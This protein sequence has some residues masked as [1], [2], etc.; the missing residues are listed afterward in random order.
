MMWSECERKLSEEIPEN[1]YVKFSEEETAEND[2]E[3]AD[4]RYNKEIVKVRER[5]ES[6]RTRSWSPWVSKMMNVKQLRKM[7]DKSLAHR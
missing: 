4:V 5:K 6:R 1:D 3:E 7:L 2:N